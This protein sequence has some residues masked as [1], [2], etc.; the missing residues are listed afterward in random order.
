MP[1]RP[2]L[3]PAHHPQGVDVDLVGAGRRQQQLGGRPG[4]RPAKHAAAGCGAAGR[5][6]GGPVGRGGGGGSGGSSNAWARQPQHAR[7]A[8]LVQA[9]QWLL[10]LLPALL[11]RPPAAA[12]APD[13]N[14]AECRAAA[15]TSATFARHSLVSS[16][17]L[18]LRSLARGGGA[19]GR[20][21]RGWHAH[22][23]Q[24]RR[25]AVL[26]LPPTLCP[27][28]PSTLPAPVHD[29][30]RVQVSDAGGNVHRNLLAVP[31]PAQLVG[32]IARQRGAQVAALAQ[33][34]GGRQGAG[35]QAGPCWL[36]GSAARWCRQQRMMR[37]LCL[38]R[39]LR[40]LPMQR[41]SRPPPSA[42]S[43]PAAPS[44]QPAAGPPRTRRAA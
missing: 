34:E 40:T 10:P 41:P 6:Q 17:F 39:L 24:R 44:P 5:A 31:P 4:Q 38:L 18:D 32:G 3:P 21:L 26:S 35:W 8:G 9:R 20:V 16:T 23:T 15:P 25:T 37:L 19:A 12:A 30:V 7:E 29:V 33:W 22:Q 42:A 11:G 27:P 43:P 28:P 13:R 2:V 14:V 1:T 36:A